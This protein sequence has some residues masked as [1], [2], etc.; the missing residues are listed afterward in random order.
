[1][2]EE[3]GE[4]E[5]SQLDALLRQTDELLRTSRAIL[6]STMDSREHINRIFAVERSVSL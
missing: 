2:P 4:E 5:D 3:L 1:M 6:D